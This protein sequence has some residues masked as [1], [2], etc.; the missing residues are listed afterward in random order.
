VSIGADSAAVGGWSL[1]VRRDRKVFRSGEFLFGFTASYRMGQLLHYSFDEKPD[2][3]MW[4]AEDLH[5]YMA[6]TFIDAVRECLKKGG[7]AKKE[8][9]QESG[10]TF[11][12][13]FR[14]HLYT[15]QADY[16][17]SE[18]EDNYDA[19][20][21]GADVALGVLYATKRAGPRH[22]I[23]QALRAAERH[24][25]GVRAPFYVEEV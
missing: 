25:A 13:G 17:V 2:S 24:N 14:Q 4:S 3:W 8:S 1:T 6:T 21:C 9:E 5:R 23:L 11:L 18:A 15:I 22:R 19:V 12:V 20:G 10:G 16:Q 7:Y